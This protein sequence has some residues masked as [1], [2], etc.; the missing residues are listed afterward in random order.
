M[1]TTTMASE[2]EFFLERRALAL[3]IGIGL[4]L[5]AVGIAIGVTT[6]SQII[7]F[8]GFYTFLGIGLS[9]MAVRVSRLVE[10]GPTTRYPFGREA[11]TPLIIGVEGVA[12]LA[13]CAYATFNAVL[14]IVGGGS[15]L[16]SEWGVGYACVALVLPTALWWWLKRTAR[17]SELAAAE[18]TQWLA[19]GVLGLGMLVAFVFARLIVGTDWSPAS[20]YV[21]PALVI[22]A[23]LVFV[24]PPTRMIRTTFIELVEGRPDT[25]LE[26]PARDAVDNVCTQ[27][28]LGEQHLRMTK[29]GRKFYVEIDF[30]VD[31]SWTVRQ[32]DEVR[33]AL[34]E[35]LDLLPHDLW[36]TVEFTADRSWGE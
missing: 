17:R 29:V 36:L 33:H 11:L 8:D 14:T 28:G 9:W 30:V 3:S 16:P 34:T 24:V 26:G 18:A 6:G 27:F 13:T 15:K 22:V 19:G 32:S 4:V 20:R 31:P 23:C 25:E 10:H 12:L 5:A 7:L 21:D 1:S 35:R 2:D